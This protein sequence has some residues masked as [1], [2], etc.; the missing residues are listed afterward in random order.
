MNFLRELKGVGMTK[1]TIIQKYQ[2]AKT[3]EELEN[4]KGEVWSGYKKLFSYEQKEVHK[5][6]INKVDKLN[7]SK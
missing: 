1:I 2:A 4:I 5:V 6:F 7:E 3:I